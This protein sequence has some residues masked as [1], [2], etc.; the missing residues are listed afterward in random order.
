MTYNQLNSAR[1]YMP[2]VQYHQQQQNN[3]MFSDA[4]AKQIETLY[5]QA[6]PGA[7]ILPGIGLPSQ[8]N[9][10]MTLTHGFN[11]P[12]LK[13]DNMISKSPLSNNALYSAEIATSA[14]G[15]TRKWIN[16]Y[17]AMIPDIPGI[18]GQP[19]TVQRYVNA[20][21][22]CG[23]DVAGVHVHWTGATMVPNDKGVWAIHHQA[24]GM[25]PVTFS[26]CTIESLKTV[27]A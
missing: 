18:D 16:L 15:S 8:G 24:I 1:Q 26:R 3:S 27:I 2:M 25:D 4:L 12:M 17:E 23:L 10:V 19:S 6:F 5:K 14:D 13:I 22:D 21:H 9:G 20:L 11:M 7:A